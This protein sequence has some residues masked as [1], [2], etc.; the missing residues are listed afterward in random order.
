MRAFKVTLNGKQL[1]VAGIG[2]NGNMSTVITHVEGNHKGSHIHI[3]GLD[4]TTEEHVCWDEY[5]YRKL[6]VGDEIRVEVIEVESVD[7]PRE[8]FRVDR[9]GRRI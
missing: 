4:M 3:G 6:S 8:R 1:C 5:P 7:E 9:S 2:E